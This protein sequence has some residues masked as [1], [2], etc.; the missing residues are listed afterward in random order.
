MESMKQPEFI[1]N[2]SLRLRTAHIN[3]AWHQVDGGIIDRE[4]EYLCASCRYIVD[5][6]T[7]MIIVA[8]LPQIDIIYFP[9][10]DFNDTG[11]QEWLRVTLRDHITALA[12]KVLPE[13][14]RYWLENKGLAG[15]GVVIKRLPKNVLGQCTYDN[16][17]YLPPMLVIFRS[18]WIDGVILHEIAHFR[19]KHH[20]KPFWDHLSVL[21][22]EDARHKDAKTDICLAPYF[23]YYCFLM[24]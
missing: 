16:V 13:R 9:S 8:D 10:T 19:H 5:G 24:K 17:I 11:I 2:P 20:R 22:G 6:H 21:L 23:P 18:D 1:I 3:V 7:V 14:V 15:G 4:G 12:E